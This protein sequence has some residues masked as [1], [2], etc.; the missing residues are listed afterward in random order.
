MY[1]V[2]LAASFIIQIKTYQAVVFLTCIM[3]VKFSKE[4]KAHVTILC[5]SSSMPLA[6]QGSQASLQTGLRLGNRGRGAG[7]PPDPDIEKLHCPMRSLC[8]FA[9][10][11][12]HWLGINWLKLTIVV[13]DTPTP[14]II[15]LEGAW[16]ISV[17]TNPFSAFNN[18]EAANITKE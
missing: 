8:S 16:C 5:F 10:D 9:S 3:R 17:T 13:I 11:F 7:Q 18:N 4:L 1:D 14:M 2:S 6:A 12:W 15:L